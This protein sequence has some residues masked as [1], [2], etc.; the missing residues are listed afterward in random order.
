MTSPDLLDTLQLMLA[1]E[2]E[3]ATLTSLDSRIVETAAAEVARLTEEIR[4]SNNYDLLDQCE[5]ISEHLD[6]IQAF[7][8]QKIARMVGGQRPENMT[9]A[10]AVYFETLETAS[11]RLRQVWRIE[12]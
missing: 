6:E 4:K 3:G 2:R 1:A 9:P 8:M 11:Q 7:R 5:A 10:E 12:A